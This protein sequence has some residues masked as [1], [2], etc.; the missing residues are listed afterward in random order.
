MFTL[1]GKLPTSEDATLQEFTGMFGV[2]SGTNR[3]S[4]TSR[5]DLGQLNLEVLS[6]AEDNLGPKR[7]QALVWALVAPDGLAQIVLQTHHKTTGEGLEYL[8]WICHQRQ[9]LQVVSADNTRIPLLEYLRDGLGATFD[10]GSD[11]H[12]QVNLNAE[13]VEASKEE[14]LTLVSDDGVATQFGRAVLFRARRHERD[15]GFREI[16]GGVFIPQGLNRLRGSSA[17]VGKGV[18]VLENQRDDFGTICLFLICQTLF[19]LQRLRETRDGLKRIADSRV[20]RSAGLEGADILDLLRLERTLTSYRIRVSD[21]VEGQLDG[22]QLPESVVDDFRKVLKEALGIPDVLAATVALLDTVEA[23]V[24][25]LRDQRNLEADRLQ[26]RREARWASFVA[27]IS[28]VTIP[29]VGVFAYFSLKSDINVPPEYSI[30][31]LNRYLV[32]WAV[33]GLVLLVMLITSR[34]VVRRNRKERYLGA[35][36]L[37]SAH[38]GGAC[39]DWSSYDSLSSMSEAANA[40][41]DLIEMDIQLDQDADIQSFCVRHAE[42]GEAGITYPSLEDALAVVKNRAMAHVDLK[43]DPSVLQCPPHDAPHEVLAQT[44][45]VQ[46]YQ[47]CR[48]ELGTS[49]FLVTSRH[50]SSIAIL[51]EWRKRQQEPIETRLGYSLGDFAYSRNL[52]AALRELFRELRADRVIVRCGADVV[53]THSV[54]ARLRYLRWCERRGYLLLVWTVD[55]ERSMGRWLADKR[56]WALVTN[57]PAVAVRERSTLEGG[58]ASRLWPSSSRL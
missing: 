17:L 23:E 50:E 57:C 47:V 42:F 33:A 45:E 11:V 2:H 26:A 12:Q 5:V 21:Q 25:S 41:A 8:G 13:R 24:A 32:P 30:F 35:R 10:L 39:D 20:I 19:A 55:R 37:I 6:D 54:L 34:V 18:S 51:S 15:L 1:R 44:P 43:F 4:A 31:D 28:T 14:D 36:T 29:V 46:A 40:G 38:R 52:L 16:P 56:V 3:S 7:F 53:A 9:T 49:A 27:W 48:A 58:V 22:F